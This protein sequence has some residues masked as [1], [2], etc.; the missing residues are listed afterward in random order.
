MKRINRLSD[1]TLTVALK[2]SEGEHITP[3]STPWEIHIADAA[4]T[5]WRCSFD[6]TNYEDCAVVDEQIICFVDNPGFVACAARITFHNNVPDANFGDGVYNQVVPLTDEVYFYD[7]PT[8]NDGEIET[9]LILEYFSAQEHNYVT[10][11]ELDADLQQLTAE[12]A[13]TYATKTQVEDMLSKDELGS[14]V[15]KY[16]QLAVHFTGGPNDGAWRYYEGA[17]NLV[18][19]IAG[20][21][22]ESTLAVYLIAL[23]YKMQGLDAIKPVVV[24]IVCRADGTPRSVDYIPFVG[25]LGSG[26]ALFSVLGN[27]A[28]DAADATD[29]VSVHYFLDTERQ[30]WQRAEFDFTNH[31]YELES[32]V[33]GLE[34]MKAD[35]TQLADYLTTSAAASTYATIAAMNAGLAEKADK[36]AVTNVV[37]QGGMLPNVVYNLG[38]TDTVNITLASPTDNTVANIYC[39]TFTAESSSCNVSLPNGCRYANETDL[40][41]DIVAGYHYEVTI[42]KSSDVGAYDVVYSYY[43]PL[44]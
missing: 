31:I 7:G 44:N 19:I 12:V 5:C 32:S 28:D 23:A 42:I 39:F 9:S 6:G 43:K 27:S 2:N 34:R 33:S 11:E 4:G 24:D 22:E 26:T 13:A 20:T 30:S 38:T 3:P 8:D 16:T 36:V 17:K 18:D 21:A 37:P 1:F 35:K 10:E 40:Q 41:D 15:A 14:E 25:M 29:I